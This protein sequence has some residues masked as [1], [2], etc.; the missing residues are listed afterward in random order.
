[1]VS[2]MKKL[3][4]K[5]PR[6]VYYLRIWLVMSK[7]AFLVVL[8]HKKLFFLFL[9]GK[10]LRFFFFI[11]FL[12]FI[13]RGSQTLAGYDINQ[14]IFFFLTFNVIDIFSQFLF[15]EVYRFRHLVVKGDFDLVLVKPTNALF[16][17]LMG[18]ADVIDLVTIPPLL[19]ALVYV[20]SLLNPTFSEV[21][22]YFVLIA[23]GLLIAT[24]FHIAVLAL[25]II[26]LEID[27]TIMIFRDLSNL[28][29]LP[30][31]IYKQ[32]LRGV[33]T[34]L[35]PVGVMITLPAKSLMGL[36]SPAGVLL[37]LVLGVVATFLATRFWNV[38]LKKYTS[39][40]S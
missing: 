7:N 18:G 24:A 19:F 22:Y 32:P 23:N 39:A 27:H 5:A 17:A 38:A 36:V 3:T 2:K 21:V 37:S 35:I 34:F 31:D 40:S 15:R 16:R 8:A 10:L 4:L 29:R 13:V 20:G 26:T 28:G 14:I 11:A 25:G 33:I 6:I 9:I 1:M 12:F 30:V